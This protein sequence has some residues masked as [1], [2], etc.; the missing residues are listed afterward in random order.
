MIKRYDLGLFIH[1]SYR[2]FAEYD[3]LFKYR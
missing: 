1:D 2:I 3:E